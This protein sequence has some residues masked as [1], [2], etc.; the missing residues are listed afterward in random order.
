MDIQVADLLAVCLAVAF[1][2]G[3]TIRR[4]QATGQLQ[5]TLKGVDDPCTLAD[6][7]AQRLILATLSRYFPTLTIIGEETTPPDPSA[8]LDLPLSSLASDLRGVVG[9]GT[10]NTDEVVV[11]VDPLDGTNAFVK[12]ELDC[13]TTLI[14]VARRGEAVFGVVHCPFSSPPVSYWGGEGVGCRRTVEGEAFAGSELPPRPA[15]PLSIVTSS[16]HSRPQDTAFLYTLGADRI[17]QSSGSGHKSVLVLTGEAT[18]YVY[19][20]LGMGKWDTCA[21]EA[22]VKALGGVCIDMEG[23]IMSYEKTAERANPPGVTDIQPIYTFDREFAER[24]AIQ[25]A[26]FAKL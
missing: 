1:K 8:A 23:R 18:A 6:L 21:T 14:G 24:A 5:V 2:A 7:S 3:E 9:G 15:A 25:Y 16:S 19:P 17:F 10:L 13:V 11:W 20:R 4:V 26:A 12:G 22:L